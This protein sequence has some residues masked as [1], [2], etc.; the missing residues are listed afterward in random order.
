M[1]Q[2][3]KPVMPLAIAAAVAAAA[4]KERQCKLKDRGGEGEILKRVV[5]A[6]C[7]SAEIHH[8]FGRNG[9]ALPNVLP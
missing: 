9:I 4:A 6:G 7:R 1:N 5:K 8:C 2:K 3:L